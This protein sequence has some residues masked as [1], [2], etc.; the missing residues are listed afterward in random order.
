MENNVDGSRFKKL[1][2]HD[3]FH[4]KDHDHY[5]DVDVKNR[6]LVMKSKFK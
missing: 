3:E 6:S 4:H 5:D 2:R 1:K